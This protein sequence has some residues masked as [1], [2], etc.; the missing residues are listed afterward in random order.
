[1]IPD[2]LKPYESDLKKYQ[3]EFISIN[4]HPKNFS[5]L[6]DRLDIKRSKFLGKPFFPANKEYP[7][8]ENGEPMILVAQLNFG[9]VPDLK[10]FPSSGIL[11][12][13]FSKTDWYEEDAQIVYH[14]ESE[15][16]EEIMT[17]F[18]FLSIDDYEE[19]PV[20]KIHELSYEKSIDNGGFEDSQFDYSFDDL[21][22]WEFEE[23]LSKEDSDAL[24]SYFDPYGHKIGGYAAFT[25]GD[26]REYA[27]NNFNDIQLLQ[28][29]VDKHIM[30]GDSGLGHIFINEQ[31][32]INKRFDK[33]YF[34]WD[35]C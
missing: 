3:R 22:D 25:Q 30:F 35:C 18:S 2:F 7:K 32:L 29:D 6:D 5:L 11:Q 13:F 26:P 24:H 16:Q 9:E 19:M 31:D 28:I 8:D 4:A 33:A 10:P 34:Y 14:H 27:E 1:M 20:F 17:D 15:M 23:S 21:S 12:L